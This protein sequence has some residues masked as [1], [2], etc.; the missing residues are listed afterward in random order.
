[1]LRQLPMDRTSRRSR[2]IL[3]SDKAVQSREKSPTKIQIV[4]WLKRAPTSTH[5]YLK[6]QESV[7]Y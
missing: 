1:V 2:G 4:N 7:E 5:F 3:V 6:E